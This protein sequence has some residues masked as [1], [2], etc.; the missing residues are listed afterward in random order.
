MFGNRFFGNRYFGG[1]Y[2]AHDGVAPAPPGGGSGNLTTL[3]HGAI[4]D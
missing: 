2:F 4:G 1:R 3:L